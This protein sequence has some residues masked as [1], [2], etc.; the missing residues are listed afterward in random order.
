[1]RSPI[2]SPPRK[3]ARRRSQRRE[4]HAELAVVERRRHHRRQRGTPL[5]PG[6]GR[7][8]PAGE[9]L[10]GTESPAS[11]RPEIDGSRPVVATLA[12]WHFACGRST[13]SSAPVATAARRLRRLLVHADHDVFGD[14]S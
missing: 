6:P 1:M 4:R 8:Q 3:A 14:Q 13:P 7:A 10:A 2:V 11:S 5:A 12:R 9:R